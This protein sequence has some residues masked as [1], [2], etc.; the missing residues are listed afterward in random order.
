MDV[1]T[2]ININIKP[3][4]E[5]ASSSISITKKLATKL[6]LDVYLDL[7]NL[8]TDFET[9]NSSNVELDQYQNLF[10]ELTEATK[11]TQLQLLELAKDYIPLL[12]SQFIDKKLSLLELIRYCPKHIY[13]NEGEILHK[14][15]PLLENAL[16]HL[17]QEK[18][19]VIKD[20]DLQFLIRPL[21]N[22]EVKRQIKL[23]QIEIIL[24]QYYLENYHNLLINDGQAVTAILETNEFKIQGMELYIEQEKK[25]RKNNKI[26]EE[27]ISF[28]EQ[29]NIFKQY[30]D[31]Y[32]KTL[33]F[34]SL[35]IAKLAAKVRLINHQSKTLKQASINLEVKDGFNDIP[36]KIS[37][38]ILQT[39][40]QHQNKIIISAT[41]FSK[42][43]YNFIDCIN[44]SN[45]NYQKNL[46][47][48]LIQ[49]EYIYLKGNTLINNFLKHINKDVVD[50]NNQPI[51]LINQAIDKSTKEQILTNIESLL[52][53][54]TIN[55]NSI[56]IDVLNYIMPI[57]NDLAKIEKSEMDFSKFGESVL[58]A[59]HNFLAIQNF[60]LEYIQ[61]L[62]N[63]I[64]TTRQQ[65]TTF[66]DGQQ[67]KISTVLN[68]FVRQTTFID[69]VLNE[70]LVDESYKKY[71]KQLTIL[72]NNHE[73]LDALS[74]TDQSNLYENL[75][76]IESCFR[77]YRA[78]ANI[79]LQM[80][81]EPE[82]FSN[83]NYQHKL[84]EYNTIKA[85]L[86]L[87][88]NLKDKP[89]LLIKHDF[90]ELN[91]LTI[92]TGN[93]CQLL[94][95]DI[96]YLQA[97]LNADKKSP[98]YLQQFNM[99]I[100][101]LLKI[102]QKLGLDISRYLETQVSKKELEFFNLNEKQADFINNPPNVT[103]LEEQ[104]LFE[105]QL[106]ILS[107]VKSIKNKCTTL[108]KDQS[109][110]SNIE[111]WTLKI[112]K[113]QSLNIAINEYKELL[114]SH[115]QL[116]S[117]FHNL[118]GLF[119]NDVKEYK[120]YYFNAN[121]D[122]QL[123][124]L[125][126]LRINLINQQNTLLNEQKQKI[127]INLKSLKKNLPS[128]FTANLI[129]EVG[130]KLEKR[131]LFKD[132]VSI[133]LTSDAIKECSS[134]EKLF[135]KTLE[136]E[137]NNII[138]TSKSNLKKKYVHLKNSIIRLEEEQFEFYIT[139]D[140][141]RN[142]MVNSKLE[143]ENLVN[144]EELNNINSS[145]DIN[146][147]H[148]NQ[149]WTKQQKKINL[150]DLNLKNEVNILINNLL[151]SLSVCVSKLSAIDNDPRS[152]LL[153]QLHDQL[154]AE[155]FKFLQNSKENR[156]EIF[157]DNA[158]KI[159]DTVLL[160]NNRLESL[161][162]E[163]GNSLIKKLLQWLRINILKPIVSFLNK[164]NTKPLYGAGIIETNMFFAIKELQKIDIPIL[165][166]NKSYIT[167]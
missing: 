61:L 75:I 4:F 70:I 77:N 116:R 86:D 19:R 119:N 30:T 91:K 43:Y 106:T 20:K 95:K 48:L 67:D 7:S 121:C 40:N 137:I 147:T 120:N 72:H 111:K 157:I 52:K 89:I 25:L 47:L 9:L 32:Q 41:L 33:E 16:L 18:S 78:K 74:L 26:I 104:K 154:L 151:D 117:G 144:G 110:L 162:S 101:S 131:R 165:L 65:L 136:D 99:A 54:N 124:K 8:Q 87:L 97:T 126:T 114:I 73:K 127:H 158:K 163:K 62:P 150:V 37:K 3:L 152:S 132:L 105:C 140:Y 27:N 28:I 113:Y 17:R 123:I 2:Y 88:I 94:I 139:H 56:I 130:S 6:N 5:L 161:S 93:H 142:L 42:I 36:F 34:Q 11:K 82:I 50:I 13:F 135:F 128:E 38:T 107:K 149:N 68:D 45:L 141:H 15:K 64:K 24:K 49:V 96:N 80:K 21:L 167:N 129:N 83:D 115:G 166:E 23:D 90:N 155:K 92:E 156:S 59:K 12:T 108:N 164:N 66:K 29:P 133:K 76:L 145:L 85:Q 122:E 51:Q 148:K 10:E 14:H 84:A 46:D 1:N 160:K 100:D 79:K 112:N 103:G 125:Q 63:Q 159:V 22:I 81:L 134:N 55:I 39:I 69:H 138:I 71:F 44:E 53:Q 146:Y 153:K 57:F 102:K 109:Q 35:I 118:F 58:V 143:L 31:F 98:Y 60:K